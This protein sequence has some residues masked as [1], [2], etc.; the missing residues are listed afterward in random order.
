M[1]VRLDSFGLTDRGMRREHNEDSFLVDGERGFFVVCDGVGGLN[2]G[3]VA[4][5]MAVDMIN[6]YMSRPG[7]EAEP[8]VGTYDDRVS[9]EANRLASAV[10]LA[11]QAIYESARGN[12]QLQGMGTTV[13]AALVRGDR[14]SIAHAGD[15]R[16]YMVRAGAIEQLTDDHSL[17]QEQVRKGLIS[18]AAA[19]D[20]NIKNVITRALGIEPAVEIDLDD[21]ALA[22][23]DRI[24]LCSDGLSTMVEDEAIRETVLRE[25]RPDRACKR[26]IDLANEGG[27]KDN[28]TVI[29][30]HVAKTGVLWYL[31]KI[32]GR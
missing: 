24:V 14:M 30:I 29:V 10:R 6:Q 19:R 13:A 15:S 5:R 3:E 27:G 28:I 2:A 16:V 7:V 4:S 21:V 23:G 18:Q 17:V 20:S 26:L 22:G 9:D 32:A 31:K 12:P 11:N 1:A 8:F 25:N